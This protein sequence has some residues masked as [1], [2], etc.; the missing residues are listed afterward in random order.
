MSARQIAKMKKLL[1]TNNIE[2]NIIEE[3][4]EN[5]KN[6]QLF[7][8]ESKSKFAVLFILLLGIYE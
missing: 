3:N 6:I 8:V 7:E 4:N 1:K 2:D 5:E